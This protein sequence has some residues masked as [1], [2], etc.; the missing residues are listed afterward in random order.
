[1]LGVTTNLPAVRSQRPA[2]EGSP[3]DVYSDKLREGRSYLDVL[4]VHHLD[5]SKRFLTVADG[6]LYEIDIVLTAVMARSYSLVDGFIAGFDSW[7]P[8]VAAPLLRMQIDSLLRHSPTWQRHHILMRLLVTS[9]VAASSARSR[10]LRE[11]NSR[12]ADSWN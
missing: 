11:R 2:P 12:T 10:T 8:V 7:N 6:D 3:G 9:S 5:L 4:R 1:M